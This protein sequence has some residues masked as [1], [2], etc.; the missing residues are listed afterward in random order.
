MSVDAYS[1]MLHKIFRSALRANASDGVVWRSINALRNFNGPK[2]W[3]YQSNRR[4][5]DFNVASSNITESPSETL[6]VLDTFSMTKAAP[7]K[8][9]DFH[10]GIRW[11]GVAQR[12]EGR[13]V[14]HYNPLLNRMQAQ[15]LLSIFCPSG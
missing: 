9:W 1:E 14:V 7:D 10:E 8:S 11:D 12:W 3:Q 13:E 5:E 4:M 15:M 2:Y 6:P